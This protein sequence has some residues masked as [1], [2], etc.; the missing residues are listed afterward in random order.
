[1]YAYIGPIIATAVSLWMGQ[2]KLHWDTVLAAMA[3]FFGIYLVIRSYRPPI[4]AIHM[5]H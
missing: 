5:D 1:M 2:D 3:I 4:Q